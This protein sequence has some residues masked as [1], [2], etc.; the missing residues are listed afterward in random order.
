MTAGKTV[1]SVVPSVVVGSLIFL[2][3]I[4]LCKEGLVDT[5]RRVHVLEYT[6]I[7]IIVTIMT[8]MGFTEGILAGIILANT[9]FVFIYSRKTIVRSIKTGQSLRST[10]HRLTRQQVFLDHCAH[11]IR[12]I[13]LQ[14][15]LFFGTIRQLNKFVRGVVKT[16]GDDT[17]FIVLDFG[18]VT[19]ID[20]SALE[21]FI[22]LRSDCAERGVE[23]VVCGW[24][25]ISEELFKIGLF[26]T[27]DAFPVHAFSTLNEALEWSENRLLQTFYERTAERR[28][29]GHGHGHFRVEFAHDYRHG[30][31]EEEIPPGADEEQMKLLPKRQSP[32]SMNNDGRGKKEGSG[33]APMAQEEDEEWISTSYEELQHRESLAF[34]RCMTPRERQIMEAADLALNGGLRNTLT[35]I[36]LFVYL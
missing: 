21:A 31:D 30:V 18:M 26:D 35:I 36:V 17:R 34:D 20:Y 32:I 22:R 15:Y 19:G 3:G 29:H 6:T 5:F 4:E 33:M 2:L 14:G 27:H 13:Q 24:A 25:T 12:I 16:K 1:I 7:L 10:V 28:G 11:L 8:T 9:F 23:M